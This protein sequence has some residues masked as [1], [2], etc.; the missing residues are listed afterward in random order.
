M[1]W[2]CN[3]LRGEKRMS[4]IFLHSDPALVQMQRVSSV[5]LGASFY[6]LLLGLHILVQATLVD[7]IDKSRGSEVCLQSF[8]DTISI[9]RTTSVNPTCRTCSSGE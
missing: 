4:R 6:A 5:L 3:V 7:C 1:K 8:D 2:I 9:H